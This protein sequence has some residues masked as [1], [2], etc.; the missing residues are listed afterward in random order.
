MFV[1]WESRAGVE[2]A[3]KHLRAA[4][5]CRA[6]RNVCGCDTRTTAD[7]SAAT[8]QCARRIDP[9][10]ADAS[11]SLATWERPSVR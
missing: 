6:N 11:A 5:A 8:N 2:V 9:M 10:R 1:I 3:L 4:Q 7:G